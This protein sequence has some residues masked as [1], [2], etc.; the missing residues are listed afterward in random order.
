MKTLN[1]L[2]LSLTLLAA[3]TAGNAQTLSKQSIDGYI[4][5]LQTGNAGAA[6][7]A[8]MIVSKL[9]IANPE[10]NV[11]KFEKEIRSMITSN[12]KMKNKYKLFLTA[13][14]LENPKQLQDINFETCDNCN[15]FF[16]KAAMKINQDLAGL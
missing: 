3:A 1:T 10:L 15:H 5:A 2:L 12:K 11:T 6:E 8:M 14:I 4:A 13:Y 9:K 7:S 16:Q